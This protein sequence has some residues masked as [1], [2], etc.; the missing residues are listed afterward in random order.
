MVTLRLSM[1]CSVPDPSLFG[2]CI[3]GCLYRAA[4]A[5]MSRLGGVPH[6]KDKGRLPG[7]IAGNLSQLEEALGDFTLHALIVHHLHS[8]IARTCSD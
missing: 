2:L 4:W 6:Q 8:F 3:E 5:G 1:G 7:G